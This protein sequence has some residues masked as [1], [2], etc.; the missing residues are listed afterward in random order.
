MFSSVNV[1]CLVVAE[2]LILIFYSDSNWFKKFFMHCYF[3][4]LLFF[5]F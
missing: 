1:G 3:K 5:F 4:D 2:A